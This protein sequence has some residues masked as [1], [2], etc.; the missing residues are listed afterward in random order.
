MF[1][2]MK[3]LKCVHESASS[4]DL[5]MCLLLPKKKK[6]KLSFSFYLITLIIEEVPF[7]ELL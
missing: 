1:I 2:N 4:T 6:K 3:E 7:Y 5:P